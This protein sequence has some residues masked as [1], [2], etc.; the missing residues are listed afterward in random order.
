MLNENEI[1]YRMDLAV[2]EKVPFTNY[3]TAIAYMNR[4]LERSLKVFE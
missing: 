1:K 4:I 2:K 3:G